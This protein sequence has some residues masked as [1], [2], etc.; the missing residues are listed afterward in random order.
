M[1]RVGAL[2]VYKCDARERPD[3][4]FGDWLDFFARAAKKSP[5]SW[6]STEWIRS[7]SSRKHIREEM[8]AGDLVLAWQVDRAEAVGLCRVASVRERDGWYDM[9]LESVEEFEE[10][11]RIRELRREDRELRK[12]RAFSQG[13]QGTV[14][15]TSSREA[16]ILLRVCHASR[17]RVAGSARRP[18][19]KGGAG[20]GSY[21]QNLQTERA[22]IRAAT[23]WL[24]R[25][26]WTVRSVERENLGYDLEAL[27]NGEVAHVEVKGVKGSGLAFP[28]TQNEVRQADED[29][30]HWLC[31]VTD[32]LHAKKRAL[33]W[34]TGDQLRRFDLRPVGYVASPARARAKGGPT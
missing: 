20:F 18:P 1:N 2:W 23:I 9:F 28:I 16:E 25:H 34:W 27:R 19:R 31:V 11:I 3:I 5:A 17:F 32:A 21:E 8:F 6:G 10:P 13:S 26:N 15:A 22:A 24:R 33:N 30:A 7:N 29:P 12:V 4:E 14:H